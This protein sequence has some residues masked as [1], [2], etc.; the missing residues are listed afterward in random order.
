MN[1]I[2]AGLVWKLPSP[3]FNGLSAFIAIYHDIPWYLHHFQTHP[4]TF[5]IFRSVGRFGRAKCQEHHGCLVRDWQH[6]RLLNN[7][8]YGSPAFS[9]R[10]NETYS[11]NHEYPQTI[12]L[13]LLLLMD[14]MEGTSRGKHGFYHQVRGFLQNYPERDPLIVRICYMIRFFLRLVLCSRSFSCS[15]GC[16]V[17]FLIA[18]IMPAMFWYKVQTWPRQWRQWLLEAEYIKRWGFHGVPKMEYAKIF[19]VIVM[20]IFIQWKIA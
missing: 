17:S 19:Q 1:L 15:C 3:K 14:W 20:F 8:I 9:R 4:D 13:V 10:H 7:F 6:S 16:K 5:G 11:V 2:L 18:F 12:S